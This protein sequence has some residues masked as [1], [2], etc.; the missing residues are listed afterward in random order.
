MCMLLFDPGKSAFG[1]GL[2]GAD[3]FAVEIKHKV[4]GTESGLHR[5]FSYGDAAACREIDFIP[6]LNDPA[7]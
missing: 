3:G 5:E 7:G 1:L 2:N 4:R 6:A